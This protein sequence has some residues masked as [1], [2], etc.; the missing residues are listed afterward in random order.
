[1]RVLIN[2]LSAVGVRTGIG[3]YTNEMVRE[4]R[5]FAGDD[6]VHVCQPDWVEH[7]K[8]WLS[9]LRRGVEKTRATDP[10]SGRSSW[11]HALVDRV[12]RMG[13]SLYRWRFRR[14]SRRGGY[15]LYHE[16]SFLPVE[17]D[18]P[19]IVTVHDLSVLL[20][21]E[22]HPADRV[23]EHQREF[24]RGVGRA[25]HVLA[26]SDSARQE[27]I[28]TLGLPA[29]RVTRTYMGV[30]PGLRPIPEVEV[31]QQLREL[32]LPPSYLLHVGTIEPRKNMLMLLR[33]Y[34]ALP[35]AV[36][37]HFPLVLVGGWGWNSNDV[38]AYL[39]DEARHQGVHCL[40]YLPEEHLP[41]L[42]NGAR[43]LVFPSFYEGFGLPPVEMLAC[44]GAVLASTAGAV[45]ETAGRR[46]CLIDP[47][48]LDGWNQAMARVCLDDDW[49][50]HLRQGAVE[51][52]RPFTWQRCA[53]ETWE[54]YQR[55][56]VGTPAVRRAA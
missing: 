12:R 55:V 13:L 5:H 47:D 31:R 10:S 52:A 28:R 43:A 26:I 48:D 24:E 27:I 3:H 32:G 49:W 33:A 44:G 34:C 39:H 56:I 22:W 18:L 53:V 7:A 45:A 29:D 50:H 38:R 23:A 15:D 1:M 16:P 25:M 46:A 2:G 36:R 9:R 51:A 30:R 37:E 35:A 20:H 42:Y 21:P 41:C 6:A 11:R 4:L 8:G 17:C 40:G 19:T 14:M 54:V